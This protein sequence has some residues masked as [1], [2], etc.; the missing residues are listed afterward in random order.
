MNSPA[1]PASTRSPAAALDGQVVVPGHASG[2]PIAI[3]PL[4]FWGGYDTERGIV[5]D[6]THA[7]YGRSLAGR[8]LVMPRARGSS[9]SSSVLAEALRN[10]TGPVGI[11]LADRDLILAIG[12]I[13]ANELYGLNVPV[14]NVSENVFALISSSNAILEIDAREI[15]NAARLT[16]RD[17]GR[18][19]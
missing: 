7:G 4:S 19:H 6:R 18:P 3:E 8:I 13:A 5:I 2:L 9:S 12:V 11:V 15:S 1:R 14:V 17:I 10:G 16:F